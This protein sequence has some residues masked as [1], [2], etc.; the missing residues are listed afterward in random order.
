MTGIKLIGCML[1]LRRIL[2]IKRFSFQKWGKELHLW[3]KPYRNGCL[4]PKCRRRGIIKR[5]MPQQRVWRDVRICGK[6]VFF[7]YTPREIIC[8]THGR[9][10]EIIPWADTFSQVTYRFEALAL[11]YCQSMAQKDAASFLNISPSTLSGIIH[12]IIS[13]VRDE[14]K[15]RALRTIGVDEISYHKG[16]KY[17]TIVYDLDKGC[18]VWVGRG[19][20]R[21]TIDEFFTT[22][23][24]QFQRRNIRYASCDMSKTY[25][26]AIL[27]WCPNATLVLDRFHVVKALN[28]AVDEVRKSQW[29]QLQGTAEGKAIKGYRWLLF[30]HSSNRSRQQKE[31]LK[32]LRKSNRRIW[33]AS[34]L[35]DEFESFW[36]YKSCTAA[37]KFLKRWETTA[38]KSR[39]EP[40]R[41]FVKTLRNHKDNILT[42]IGSRL[43]NAVAEGLNRIIRKVKNRASGF[44]N[45]EAFKDI[46][47]LT[48]GDVDILDQFS[49]YF[50]TY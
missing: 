24:S 27:Q 18:V 45:L 9:C 16:K 33:R 21:E 14:H 40:I 44:A 48:V 26:G 20:A 50:C 15:I 38:L 34:V 2:K 42:F 19:K 10:Q 30:M 13:R 12:R 43:T 37:A 31:L 1:N 47:Y 32:D 8:P 29:R 23:L 35:K 39:L 46:I 5:T 25:I 11:R 36:E 41:A 49:P 7:H 17:A 6:D 28:Q 22:H 3:V 4:C